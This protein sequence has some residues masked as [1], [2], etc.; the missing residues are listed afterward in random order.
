MKL[1]R[2]LTCHIY[3]NISLIHSY[4][5][6]EILQS[7]VYLLNG[8]LNNLAWNWK[9]VLITI[10]HLTLTLT[11]LDQFLQLVW[12]SS[13]PG[14]VMAVGFDDIQ[15]LES[16]WKLHST[17]KMNGLIQDLLINQALLKKLQATRIVLTTRMFEDEYTNCKNEL[18]SRSMQRI[19]I[20]TKRM[21]YQSIGNYWLVNSLH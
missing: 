13:I 18:L 5:S 6:R 1:P 12:S 9:Y 4:W 3:S 19:S 2:G 14:I 10:I 21:I 11:S 8:Y 15:A 20:K 7:Q 16:V 17:E